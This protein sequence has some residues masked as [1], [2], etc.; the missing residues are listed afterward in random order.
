MKSIKIGNHGLQASAI[1]LGCMHITELDDTAAEKLI[2]ASVDEGITFFDHSDVYGGGRCEEVFAKA[3]HTGESSRRARIQIQTKFGLTENDKVRYF[4]S[5]KKHIL[6]AVEGSLR[7][8]NTDYIDMLLVHRPDA[9]MEPEEI[10]EA[11][12]ELHTSGKV[13]HFG[14]SNFTPRQIQL[15]QTCVKQPIEVNQLQMSIVHSPMITQGLFTNMMNDNAIDRDGGV[16]DFCRINGV[17][18][19][20][21]CPFQYGF[22]DGVFLGNY[23]YPNVNKKV[24]EIARRYGVSD[25]AVCLAW[26]MRHPAGIQPIIGTTKPARLKRC[27][28]ADTFTITRSEW[29]ELY[30]ANGFVLP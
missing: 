5:S 8:L 14:V 27:A 1:A 17:G 22:G 18:L 29:Y 10:A 9:L 15:L 24:R 11:F 2:Q 12:D 21:W 28:E 4:D 26:I 30:C 3:A 6:E 23:K 20:A 16:L 13:L 7:R 19:Q 25:E